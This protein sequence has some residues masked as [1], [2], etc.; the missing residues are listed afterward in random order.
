MSQSRWM[1][2]RKLSKGETL[3]TF[4]NGSDRQGA[5]SDSNAS[6]YSASV[7]RASQISLQTLSYLTVGE[8]EPKLNSAVAPKGSF[9]F[10]CSFC[11]LP[12]LRVDEPRG[13]GKL[14]EWRWK[15]QLCHVL[16]RALHYFLLPQRWP[17]GK[18]QTEVKPP[19]L[20]RND[21]AASQSACRLAPLICRFCSPAGI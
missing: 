9:W 13:T 4:R 19:T 10:L 8:A 3:T 1:A 20:A 7:G 5:E 17:N 18:L 21:H 16:L 2:E 12:L 14:R 6:D 15:R 11:H